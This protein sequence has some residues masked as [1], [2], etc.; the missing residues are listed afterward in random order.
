MS[1]TLSE[2]SISDINPLEVVIAGGLWT[3]V[4]EEAKRV[5]KY[6]YFRK[7]LLTNIEVESDFSVEQQRQFME[8]KRLFWWIY[9][10]LIKLREGLGRIE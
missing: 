2:W 5:W 7:L 9:C 8:M 1:D 6:M 4:N 3:I 10:L